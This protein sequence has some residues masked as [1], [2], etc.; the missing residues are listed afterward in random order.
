VRAGD[1]VYPIRTV[2]F[3]NELEPGARGRVPGACARSGRRATGLLPGNDFEISVGLIGSVNPRPV[4]RMPLEGFGPHER[5]GQFPAVRASRCGRVLS[6]ARS[7]CAPRRGSGATGQ[8]GPSRAAGRR[9]AP[10]PTRLKPEELSPAEADRE[11]PSVARTTGARSCGP[12]RSRTSR[13]RRPQGRGFARPPRSRP[14]S[15]AQ[16]AQGREEGAARDLP[17]AARSRG[18]AIEAPPAAPAE[19]RTGAAPPIGDLFAPFGR[20]VKCQLVDTVDSVT[21]RSEPIVALVTQD[22]DWN[23]TSS[24]PRAPRRSAMRARSPS[25]TRRAGSPRRQRRMDARAAR[26]P[27][28]SKRAR[29]H[30]EGPGRRPPELGVAERGGAARRGHGRRLRRACRLHAVDAR[31]HGDQAVRGGRD[32]RHGQGSGPSPSASS[33][34]RGAG[35]PGATQAA[36][37][38]GN[39]LPARSA[40][41]PP[42]TWAARVPDPR[43]DIEARRLRPR[44]RGQGVLSVCRADDRPARGGGRPQ[45][46]PAGPPR[47]EGPALSDCRGPALLAPARRR[48]APARAR[49]TAAEPD[50]AVDSGA[51]RPGPAPRRTARRSGCPTGSPFPQSYRLMLV[52][53]HLALVRETDP[54]RSRR[55]PTSM[56]IVMGEIARGELA[57]QPGLLPQE[58]AARSRPT[59]RAP[60]RMDNALDTVMQR[61]RELS[62]QAME[63]KAQAEKL[64]AARGRAGPRAR[65][66]GGRP[67]R[68]RPRRQSRIPSIPRTESRIPETEPPHKPSNLKEPPMPYL[69]RYSFIGNLTKAPELRFQPTGEKQALCILNVAINRDSRDE[70][71]EKRTHT[72]LHQRHRGLGAIR[73]GLRALP[74][75]GI[76]GPRR[77]PNGR[78]PVAGQAERREALPHEGRRRECPVPQDQAPG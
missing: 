27:G 77:G 70:N 17:H 75:R 48:S 69:N 3:A 54:R 63:L 16:P 67:R 43:R 65:A 45:A 61:S 60:R 20:L 42:T 28:R 1:R 50:P 62:D 9:E 66:R 6:S 47:D 76:D 39:A 64:A 57:Y 23:G 71:G 58:L 19:G 78:R 10:L 7:P 11:A 49:R 74:D 55:A 31:Q 34:A 2:D 29:A 33:R 5:R 26:R 30:P 46:P 44:P 14:G 36:P 59:A 72:T 8:G 73:R 18:P 68:P 35:R 37:T 22:L 12:S 4:I 52:D 32:Q 21:A 41:A 25:S 24:S 53:G 56:R 51:P 13:A 40:P 38:L 15:P